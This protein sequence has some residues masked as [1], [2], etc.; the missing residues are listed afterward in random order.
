MKQPELHLILVNRTPY[1]VWTGLSHFRT[2]DFLR[3][4]NP[5]YH[6]R[7]ARLLEADLSTEDPNSGAL[8]MRLLHG[9]ASEAFF[10]LLFAV[11]QAPDAPAAWLLLYRP[12][13]LDELIRRLEAGK[14]L[15]CRWELTDTSWHGIAKT[16]IPL[17]DNDVV[18]GSEV[19]QRFG[20]YWARLAAEFRDGL[21]TWELN[22]LKHGL[23][24]RAAAPYFSLGGRQIPSAEHG[25]WFPVRRVKGREVLLNIGCR[26][27]SAHSLLGELTLIA[28]SLTNLLALLKQ[29]H[30][31][32]P[33]GR[34]ELELPSEAEF[35][36]AKAPTSQMLSSL[37][38]ARDWPQHLPFKPLDSQV[39]LKI[40]Q[41]L[42]TVTVSRQ[43]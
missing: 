42:G 37:S 33:A 29:L 32:E 38:L 25:S 4:F 43:Q 40:Y 13:D 34:L 21:A 31:I 11:L 23:R 24:A 36:A 2:E 17:D 12:G 39:A 22:S 20:K 35:E 18:G 6:L 9:L 28:A 14:Q 16:L 27:W 10:A 19:V 41:S 3:G 15:P 26:A 5:I 7:L 1:R 30:G 8:G